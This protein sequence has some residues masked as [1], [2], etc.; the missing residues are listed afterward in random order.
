MYR[1]IYTSGLCSVLIPEI[2][3]DAFDFVLQQKCLMRHPPGNEI[4]RH[5]NISL[6]EID[7]RKNK[8]FIVEDPLPN[9]CCLSGSLFINIEMSE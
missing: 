2:N 8:V 6:F 9:N 4:Y 1:N 3:T 7:G 5:E